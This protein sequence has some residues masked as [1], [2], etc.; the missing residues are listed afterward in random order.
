MNLPTASLFA[1][2]LLLVS[3]QAEPQESGQAQEKPLASEAFLGTWELIELEVSQE[4]VDGLDSNHH[5]LIEEADWLRLYGVNP[6]RTTFTADGKFV[7]R[8]KLIGAEEPIITHGIWTV[9]GDSVRVIEPNTVQILHTTFN[10]TQDQFEWNG[11]VDYDSDKA[12]DD[13]YRAKYR[14]VGRTTEAVE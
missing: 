13:T 3:C 7:R 11:L 4:T 12:I 10:E 8:N 1:I 6:G 9:L 2:G 14:L 5:R